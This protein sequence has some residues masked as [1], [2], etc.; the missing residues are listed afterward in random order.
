MNNQN[1]L[2]KYAAYYIK[3]GHKIDSMCIIAN[4][5]GSA[6][7]I[8]NKNKYTGEK[9]YLYYRGKLNEQN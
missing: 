3:N 7:K 6:K 9:I 4:N 8:A 2:H 5:K 1:L